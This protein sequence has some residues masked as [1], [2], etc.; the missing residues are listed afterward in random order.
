[1][2]TLHQ[3]LPCNPISLQRP[4][5]LPLQAGYTKMAV[6]AG[7]GTRNYYRKLGYELCETLPAPVSGKGKS[8]GAPL[9]A[10]GGYMIKEL[11][12]PWAPGN[13]VIMLVALV[14]LINITLLGRRVVHGEL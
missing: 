1:M 13:L 6:I 5:P 12:S 14:L 4:P 7:I 2:T 8:G 3:P 9:P 11:R 10:E